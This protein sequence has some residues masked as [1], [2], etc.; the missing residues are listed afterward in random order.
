MATRALVHLPQPVRR[1]EAVEVRALIQHPMETGFRVDSQGRILPRDI[2]RRFECRLDGELIFSA[3]LHPA[4]AANPYIAFWL[5]PAA[6][7]Q[8]LFTWRG[9]NGFSHEESVAL[10]VA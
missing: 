3:D 5:R 10:V 6:N 7:G 8:L 9:D 4:M 2:V 1:G